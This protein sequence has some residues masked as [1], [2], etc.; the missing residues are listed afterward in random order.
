[1]DFLQA[2]QILEPL[3]KNGTKH[4]DFE[5]TEKLAKKYRQLMTG[6]EVD[7]LLRRF[8]P[9][10][11][12]ELFNQRKNLFISITPALIHSVMKPFYKVPRTTPI[13]AKVIVNSDSKAREAEILKEFSDRMQ[14]YYGTDT[15]G[16]GI[17]FYLQNRFIELSALDPNAWIVTEWDPF[18]ERVTKPMPYPF[19]VSSSMALN[20]GIRNNQTEW[21]HVG[22][23]VKM[24]KA[25][26]TKIVAGEKGTRHYLYG[27]DVAL[28]YEQTMLRQSDLF[29]LAPD[30]QPVEYK[31]IEGKF[32]LVYQSEYNLGRVP[33][34]RVGYV[35]DLQ[36]DG[37]TFVAPFH[38]AMPYLDKAIKQVSEYDLSHALH[39]FPQ[40]IVR[41]TETCKGDGTEDGRCKGG[42]LLDGTTCKVCNGTSRPVHTSAQDIIEIELPE[43]IKDDGFIPL[44][45][46]V[47]Y[48]ELPV[49]LLKFQKECINEFSHQVHQA[50][51]NSTA[52]LQQHTTQGQTSDPQKTAFEVDND[53]DSVYD[54]LSPF[55]DKYSASWMSIVE[56]IS[57]LTDNQDNVT[58]IHRFPSRF[59][60]KTRELLYQEYKTA[61][62]SS[63]PGFVIQSIADELAETVFMDDADDLLKYRV[64]QRFFPFKG[65]TRPEIM[66]ALTSEQVLKETKTLYYYFDMIF[67][68]LESE[69]AKNKSDFYL[70]KKEDQKAAID[71][72]VQELMAKIKSE[73][74]TVIPFNTQV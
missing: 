46:L 14:K 19:E 33:A 37:R 55:A 48:V 23:E 52:L 24:W 67:D 22:E 74:E 25:D 27:D 21:L 30:I 70:L 26:G 40:K 3:I 10:E 61:S 39:I 4:R 32:Y 11:S 60:L 41:L 5:H 44:S 18:D 12:Q 35:R 53:M 59:K 66:Q 16:D 65:K 43:N 72:K 47:H 20:F 9:R 64:K 49:E 2:S 62:E 6:H 38:A 7:S 50:V 51:F 57:I 17:D 8:N 1:M 15:G 71:K 68:E 42:K 58:F 31:E 13:S 45:E 29:L 63:L 69:N 34:F 73:Q 56:M 36:T 54:T 28:V